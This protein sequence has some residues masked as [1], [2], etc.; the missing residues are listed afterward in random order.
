MAESDTGELGTYFCQEVQIKTF[1]KGLLYPLT[2]ILGKGQLV[3]EK[4][5]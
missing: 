1:N 5:H 2:K 4:R 3:K